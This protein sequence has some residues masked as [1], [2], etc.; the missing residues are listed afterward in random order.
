MQK[1]Q[2]QQM[3]QL[4][5]APSRQ[6][7]PG[8]PKALVRGKIQKQVLWG[9]LVLSQ[10]EWP[11]S[12]VLT[13]NRAGSHGWEGKATCRPAHTCQA[14]GIQQ[15]SLPVNNTTTGTSPVSS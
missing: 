11:G 3:P 7:P 9:T 1:C 13:K 14:E 8:A 15:T 4:L 2:E 12:R 5:L 6:H 10:R